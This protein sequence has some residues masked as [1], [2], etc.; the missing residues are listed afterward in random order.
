MADQGPSKPAAE[1]DASE[2]A[3]RGRA[4]DAARGGRA[5]AVTQSRPGAF[6]LDTGLVIRMFA[7][8]DDALAYTAPDV[9]VS[10][11]FCPAC[12][13]WRAGVFRV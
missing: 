11:A 3:L 9:V 7:A 6:N 13:L 10:V 5:T 2:D 1:P 8:P 4:R 12:G